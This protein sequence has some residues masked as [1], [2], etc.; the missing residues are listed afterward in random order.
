M[1]RVNLSIIWGGGGDMVDLSITLDDQMNLSITQM[2]NVDLSKTQ[3]DRVDLSITQGD[4][5]DLSKT[6]GGS[7]YN[8]GCRVDLSTTQRTG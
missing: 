4:R 8:T 2:D 3:A 6:Q 1:G 5:M 7:I